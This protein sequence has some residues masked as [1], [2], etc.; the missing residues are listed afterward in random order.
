[1]LAESN[2]NFYPPMS[3]ED[4]CI[5]VFPD[6]IA[7]VVSTVYWWL[8]AANGQPAPAITSG[9][10]L[11]QWAVVIGFSWQLARNLSGPLAGWI[12]ASIL[13]GS[14]FLVRQIGIG[15]ETGALTISLLGML[16]V[17]SA[18]GHSHYRIAVAGGLLAGMGALSR[19]YGG[20]IILLGMVIQAWRWRSSRAMLTFV[21]VAVLIAAPWY[22]RNLVRCG[23]P[24]HS[25]SVLGFPPASPV[26]AGMLET[27]KEV[28]SLNALS[29]EQW[30]TAA[31]EC[32]YSMPIVMGLGIIA[33][34][35][36][37]KQNGYLAIS[38]AVI[39]A[40]WHHSISYTAGGLLFSVR[41][42]TPA[43]ALAAVAV[44][45]LGAWFIS[46]R[47]KSWSVTLF[48]TLAGLWGIAMAASFPF[49]LPP[50]KF[51][52]LPY[53]FV[54]PYPTEF[55]EQRLAHLVKTLE[56]AGSRILTESAYSLTVMVE[57]GYPGVPMWSPEVSYLFDGV[58]TQE[59][60]VVRLKESGIHYLLF[61][62]E[63]PDSLFC[64]KH[65]FF[66][67]GLRL[68]RISDHKTFVL[69][70]LLD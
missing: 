43:V 51:N 57:V 46:N 30:K 17:L 70:K 60:C 64:M 52:Q 47:V 9:F 44:G 67:D 56:P 55:A 25:L 2:L 19:E 58:T 69:C 4:Y 12:A 54:T 36:F 24:F 62:P 41:V 1:M 66:K 3:K 42:L 65:R 28:F 45:L 23:N 29:S 63:S 48:L 7:P 11:L 53:A 31:F 22:L 39:M 27:Y 38:I 37:L 59:Q 68:R 50:Q 15:Q 49:N 18:N 35:L 61:F 6:G 16:S 34:I 40:L 33:S 21:G 10:V 5:Y 8:Y 20:V 13:A 14:A 32:V 26:L